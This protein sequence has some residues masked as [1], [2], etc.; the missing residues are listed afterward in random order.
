MQPQPQLAREE[1][2]AVRE[3]KRRI[4]FLQSAFRV[5]ADTSDLA[6]IQRI[7][8]KACATATAARVAGNAVLEGDS[9]D[10]AQRAWRRLSALKRA[11]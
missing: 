9:G 6:E 5:I 11:H 1:R 3:R 2:K 7:F 10:I 4:E 8:D